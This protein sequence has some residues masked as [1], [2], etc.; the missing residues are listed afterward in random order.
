MTV[1]FA[2][3]GRPARLTAVAFAVALLLAACG[4]DGDQAAD[5][6]TTPGPRE[7]AAPSTSAAGDARVVEHVYGESIVPASPQRVVVL[8]SSTILATALRLDVPV[9]ATAY[10]PS[11]EGLVGYL[12]AGRQDLENIG[13]IGEYD[14]E[15][16]TTLEPDLIIGNTGFISEDTYPLL[17]E[18]APTVAFEMF[19]SADWKEAVRTAAAAFGRDAEIEEDIAQFE[20]RVAEFRAA[21][22]ERHE[23]LEVSILNFRAPGEVHIYTR[24]W[25]AGQVLAEAGLAQPAYSEPAEGGRIIVSTE[26]LPEVDADA[27]LYFVGSSGTPEREAEDAAAEITSNPLW[28]QLGAVQSGRAHQV[29]ASHWFTCGPLEAQHLV[30]DDLFRLLAEGAS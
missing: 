23:D 28:G 2:H 20:S 26:R 19:G 7:T 14:L 13:W 12:P 9:I 27:I 22:G 8:H 6:T 1:L 5:D 18:I 15:K 21:M 3:F 29:D 16:I 30:L 17:R 4:G 11:G 24:E 25:C 10:P